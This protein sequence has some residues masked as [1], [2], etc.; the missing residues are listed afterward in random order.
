[1]IGLFV[2]PQTQRDRNVVRRL[3]SRLWGEALRDDTK[4]G[5]GKDKPTTSLFLISVFMMLV[6][7]AGPFPYFDFA[8]SGKAFDLLYNT[9]YILC[10][11]AMLEACDVTKHGCHLVFF[12]ELEIWKKQYN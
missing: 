7:V 4:D 6:G 9:K 5:C 1:M 12:Q 11:V 10:V 2:R 8:F 3:S